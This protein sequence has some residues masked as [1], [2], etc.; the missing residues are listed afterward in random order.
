ML[1]TVYTLIYWGLQIMDDIFESK[2][3]VTF[4]VPE[5]ADIL[6][7]S[8]GSAYQG[9]HCGDIPSIR[10]GERLLVPKA[11]LIAMLEKKEA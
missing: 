7:I 6:G 2:E 5:A 10:I 8:R 3:K 4:S 1:I 9:V 11:A